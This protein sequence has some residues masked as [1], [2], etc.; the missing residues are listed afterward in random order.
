MEKLIDK[1]KENV[2]NNFYVDH[3]QGGLLLEID[4]TDMLNAKGDEP[5]RLLTQIAE[6]NQRIL[7]LEAE[8][9]EVRAENAVIRTRLE[10]CNEDNN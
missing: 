4:L 1:V 10:N 3:A 8:V 6:Q 5:E 9:G 2:M 7:F